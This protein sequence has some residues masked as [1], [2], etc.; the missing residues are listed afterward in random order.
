MKIMKNY[1]DDEQRWQA[2]VSCD[3]NAD[4]SFY[5]A[6]I[7]TGVYCHPSCKS[8]TPNRKNLFYF[9][10]HGQAEAQGYRPCKRCRPNEK[11]GAELLQEKMINACRILEESVE[12][13]SLK[14]LAAAFGYSSHHFHRCFKKI[15][16]ITPKQY[17]QK[18]RIR[19]FR[20]ELGDSKPVL[21]AI[22]AAGYASSSGAYDKDQEGLGMKPTCYKKGGE[23]ILIRYGV[24]Q[25]VLG[26]LIVAATERGICS[27]EFGDSEDQLLAQLHARFPNATFEKGDA[28]FQKIVGEVVNSIETPDTA[29]HLPLDIQGTAFQHSVWQALR[30][31]KPGQTA[32]YT[33]IAEKIEK[34]DAVRA[35]AGAC[36]ANKIAVLV[37]CHRVLRKDG[38]PSGYRWGVERKKALLD[39]EAARIREK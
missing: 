14:N 32:T 13:I 27:T 26:S 6:V 36:A 28:A 22:Y 34:P 8:K 15:I 38:S 17:Y 23:G 30:A 20:K 11:R 1:D 10:T 25:C 16:G 24:G 18:T 29:K 3:G 4:G 7:T 33:E 19:N 37:P 35:V 9:D 21:E 12:P 39:M 5:Y 31:L 2:V